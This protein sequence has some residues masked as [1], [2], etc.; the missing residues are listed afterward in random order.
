MKQEH[1]HSEIAYM[2]EHDF[3]EHSNSSWSS[4]C[5]LVPKPDG[6]YRFCTDFRKVNAITKTD[7]YPISRI[8]DCIDKIGY[9]KYVS[10]FDLLKKYWQVPLTKR[11]KEIYAIVTTY[12]FY[13]Y[14]IIAFG[15]QNAPAPFQLMINH[16]IL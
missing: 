6:S 3:I 14:K 12:G 7:S 15:M 16:M 4:P 9:A 10:K 1:C 11:P 8:E 5:I 13:R 2:L